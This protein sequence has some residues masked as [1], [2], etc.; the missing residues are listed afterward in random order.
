MFLQSRKE[1]IVAMRRN[2]K[3][4]YGFL[5]AGVKSSP[6]LRDPTLETGNPQTIYLYN[7]KSAKISEYRR[8][9]V[10]AKLREL[11]DHEKEIMEQLSKAY[12]EAKKSFKLRIGVPPAPATSG[13]SAKSSAATATPVMYDFD[14][15][16]DIDFSGDID[17][18]DDE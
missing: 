18:D 12:Q 11:A 5:D 14:D 8:D 4:W 7:L 1:D 10:E 13:A 16:E 2:N 15:S 3:H 17:F 6:V 9:I